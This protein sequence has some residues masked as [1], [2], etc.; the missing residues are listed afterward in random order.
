MNTKYIRTHKKIIQKGMQLL[1]SDEFDKVSVPMICEQAGISRPTFYSHFKCKEQLV[2][3]YYGASFFLNQE[4]IRWVTSAPD[5]WTS[6]IRIQLLYIRHT[7]NPEQAELIS[8]SLSYQ[9]TEQQPESVREY[10]SLH[11]EMLL[12]FI[13]KAQMEG[14]VLNRSD[15]FYL[16]KSVSM[17]QTGNLFLWCTDN[18]RF[19][20]F[21]N[22]FWNLEAVLCVNN[23]YRGLWKSEIS[24][25]PDFPSEEQP[26][27]EG[28]S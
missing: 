28:F 22:F 9:L 23:A 3:E 18:G 12:Q 8:Q 16:C 11:Q 1:F 17:L 7:C 27:T 21:T 13:K 5:Y 25:I 15:P 19:D 2:A 14:S 10:N 20:Q 6:I 4:K 24:F 26:D